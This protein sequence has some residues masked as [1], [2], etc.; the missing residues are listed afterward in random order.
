MQFDADS[1]ENFIRKRLLV[2]FAACR[3]NLLLL[4]ECVLVRIS[5]T[6]LRFPMTRLFSKIYKIADGR[7]RFADERGTGYQK[8]TARTFSINAG[9]NRP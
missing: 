7:T 1:A 4:S 8:F 6:Q 2:K 5:I 3:D 9:I